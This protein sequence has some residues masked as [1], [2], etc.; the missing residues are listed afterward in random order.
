M[1]DFPNSPTSGQI[2]QGWRWDGA[3]WNVP[4]SAAINPAL[5]NVGR[6]LL[7]NPLFN[8]QQRGQGPW[9]ANGFTADRWTVYANL[10]TVSYTIQTLADADRAAIGDEAAIYALRNAFTGNSGAAAQN[11]VSES[12]ESVRRLGGKTVTVSFWAQGS[13]A[14]KLGMC[15]AQYFGNGG[16]PSATVYTA[17]QS[18]TLSTSWARYSM[19][20]TL[21][22]TSGKTL[23]TNANTDATQLIFA[24]SSGSTNNTLYGNIGVQS[25]TIQLWGIQC[26]IGTQATP[27]EKPDPADDLR[28]CQRFYQNLGLFL[29][30]GYLNA[31]GQS[32]WSSWMLPVTMRGTPTATPSNIAYGSMTGLAVS[33]L[34]INGFTASAQSTAAAN[35]YCQFYVALSADL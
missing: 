13:A 29:F 19:T 26:E 4:S 34:S 2:F 10:D 20:F 31:S 30:G 9:T 8:V 17:G 16:S 14:L 11:I 6:N 28:H 35:C 32:M 23:G 7:H 21:A 3:K 22:S 24:F 1:L 5:N 15:I 27:L 18:V 25:G 12:M 33:N